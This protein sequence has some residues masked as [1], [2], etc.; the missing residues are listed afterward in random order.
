[1]TGQ[2]YTSIWGK[3]KSIHS[4]VPTMC[5]ATL[6]AREVLYNI[7]RNLNFNCDNKPLES[8]LGIVK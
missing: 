3:K 5:Q 7:I 6:Y 4:L 2:F 8:L 1:M